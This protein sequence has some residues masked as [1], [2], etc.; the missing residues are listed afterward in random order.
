VS[1]RRTSLLAVAAVV[2]VGGGCG[3]PSGPVEVPPGEIPFPLARSEPS[4]TP[5]AEMTAV[6]AYLVRDGRLFPVR[7][8]VL[9]FLPP[10]H[11]AMQALLA[12]PTTAERAQGIGSKIPFQTSLLQVNVVESVAQVDLSGEYQGP[13][14]PGDIVLRVAQV[15]WTL[16]VLPDVT[17]VRFSID[18]NQVDVVTDRG[19]PVDRPVTAPD[20]AEVA[21][22]GPG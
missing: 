11:A 17:A 18:G 10:D 9:G 21:P 13:A 15:V 7:R 12:G 8:E 2:A 1:V 19:L 3:R 14:P 5:V 16:V 22:H 4:A 20:F 6:T